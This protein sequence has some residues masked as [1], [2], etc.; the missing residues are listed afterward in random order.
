MSTPPFGP[1][2][3][4]VIPKFHI[5]ETYFAFAAAP[6]IL[7]RH[8]GERLK[9]L[10]PD[11]LGD[12]GRLFSHGP[13]DGVDIR[14]VPP[15]SIRHGPGFRRGEP[16]YW[17][18]LE[19]A[20]DLI[21]SYAGGT[22]AFTRM[23]LDM[24]DLPLAGTFGL[25]V[26]PMEVADAARARFDRLGLPEGQTVIL[27]PASRTLQAPPPEFW[28]RLVGRLRAQGWT[29][30]QNLPAAEQQAGGVLEGC[31]PLDCPLSEL[32]PLAE[33]AGWVISARNGLCDLLSTARTRLTIVAT[34]RAL[35]PLGTNHHRRDK[36]VLYRILQPVCAPT[37]V[38][39]DLASCGLPDTAEYF[40]LGKDEPADAFTDR[41]LAGT[42]LSDPLP[43]APACST[44]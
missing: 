25:P 44:T 10:V 1:E 24:L 8:G 42:P 19:K 27:A 13:A 3:W 37:R 2:D 16:F 4:A 9:V 40:Y 14:A 7:A 12:I 5:G 18:P 41:V 30:C 33:L 32:L 15:E 20:P 21:R 23:Y 35:N 26:V 43:L 17:H 38:L 29:V 11:Y 34:H 28:R 39:W 36:S 22:V 31:I 6:A